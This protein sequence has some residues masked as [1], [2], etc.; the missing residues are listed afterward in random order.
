M[1]L[2]EPILL[3]LGYRLYSG[4]GSSTFLGQRYFF[5]T[6]NP[7]HFIKNLFAVNN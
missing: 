3:K 4:V 2:C 6:A 5:K 1:S 7:L